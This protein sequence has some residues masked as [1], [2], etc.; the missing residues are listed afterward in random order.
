MDMADFASVSA[1]A[2]AFGE[3]YDRLD[4]LICNAGME[5]TSL[6]LTKDGHETS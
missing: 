4:I 1:F 5:S 2:T 3:K 6:E